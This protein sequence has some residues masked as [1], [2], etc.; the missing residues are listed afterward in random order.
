MTI[1]AQLAELIEINK[2]ILTALQ[3]NAQVAAAGDST[4]AQG[5][6]TRRTKAEIEAE[7]AALQ[8]EANTLKAEAATETT[9]FVDEAN[10][11]AIEVPPGDK[12]PEGH[13]FVKV[14]KQTYAAKVK[15]FEPKAEPAATTQ[16]SATTAPSATAQ[17]ADASAA[18]SEKAT[19]DEAVAKL[20]SLLTLPEHGAAA[21]VKVIQKIDPASAKVTDLKDRGFNDRIVAEVEALLTPAGDDIFG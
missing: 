7:K 10:K 15:E 19:W 6:R 18:A 17:Q 5:K 12:A 9:Y 16:A 11:L 4:E 8:A 3:S 13:G 20:K 21:E 1:E 14:D 2:Q